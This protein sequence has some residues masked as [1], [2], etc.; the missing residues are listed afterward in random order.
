MIEAFINAIPNV[1]QAMFVGSIAGGI[2]QVCEDDIPQLKQLKQQ[3]IVVMEEREVKDSIQEAFMKAWEDTYDGAKLP[4]SC[5][6][7]LASVNTTKQK[8]INKLSGAKNPHLYKV[9]YND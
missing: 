4:S 5:E 6:E 3:L 2:V 9:H 1:L 7:A 8:V